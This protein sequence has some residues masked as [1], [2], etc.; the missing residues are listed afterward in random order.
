ME[1]SVIRSI[2]ISVGNSGAGVVERPV[3]LDDRAL[4]PSVL[5]SDPHESDSDRTLCVCDE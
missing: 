5:C 4:L 2:G 3:V 1:D